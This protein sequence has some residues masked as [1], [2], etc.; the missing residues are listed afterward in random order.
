[1]LH[2]PSWHTHLLNIRTTFVCERVC[3]CERERGRCM[4]YRKLAPLTVSSS[5][6]YCIIFYVDFNVLL[7]THIDFCIYIYIYIYGKYIYLFMQFTV[8]NLIVLVC[9]CRWL[10]RCQHSFSLAKN[11]RRSVR[12]ARRRQ[13]AAVTTIVHIKMQK[14]APKKRRTNHKRK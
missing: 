11:E 7:H 5:A 6:I 14:L 1:M 10:S 3:M 9:H 13:C 8:Y 2:E 12:V 4:S